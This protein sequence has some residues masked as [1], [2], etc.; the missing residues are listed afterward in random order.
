[1]N[2]DQVVNQ[3]VKLAN[4]VEAAANK[5][6][7]PTFDIPIRALSN[8]MF[9][10]ESG[11]IEMGDAKQKRVLF[12][13]GQARRFAQTLMVATGAKRL[14]DQG[15][16]TSI[17]D[18]YYMLKHTIQGSKDNTFEAQEESDPIIE[19]VEVMTQCLREEL[20]L[21]A[22]NRG[23][24]VGDI[25]VVDGGDVIDC[26]RMGT[27]G[28]SVPSIVEP[29]V[30]QFQKCDAEFILLMEK[31][32]MWRRLNED[33][34]WQ[35]N[36][37]IL[38][39][40]NGQPPRGVRRLVHRMRKELDLPVYVFVDND[41][42]GYYIYSVV[43]QGSI[44]LSFESKRMAIPDARFIGLSAFDKKTFGLTDN[45]TIKLSPQDIA[46]A[47]Q[48]R[49]YEWFKGHRDWQREIKKLLSN[50]FKMEL[51]ALSSRG[52]TF[53]AEEYLPKQIRDKKWLD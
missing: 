48:I 12:S 41:P 31:D 26:R 22:S 21:Y 10:Q 9:N 45:V 28:W 8:A 40:G 5:G 11:I 33:K 29:N 35:K 47:K 18:L 38:V 50:G 52:L 30:V 43:K 14:K 39:H 24:L 6:G 16:T 20:N 34:Y 49:D 19:D 4:D 36:K 44:N 15:L 46:R 32:A 37:C 51:E 3:L 42:W 7:N 53:V 1:M 23:A 2:D 17:R 13:L 27:G 25:T